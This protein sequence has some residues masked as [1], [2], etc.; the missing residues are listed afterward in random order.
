MDD[1]LEREVDDLLQAPPWALTRRLEPDVYAELRLH[2]ILCVKRRE[3]QALLE[4][5]EKLRNL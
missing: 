1:L 4:S 2:V 3:R 5:L